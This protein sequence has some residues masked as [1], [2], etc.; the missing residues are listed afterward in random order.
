MTTSWQQLDNIFS[1]FAIC[2]LM[3][4]ALNSQVCCALDDVL[5]TAW[6]PHPSYRGDLT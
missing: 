4:T 3:L 5:F 2:W 1:Q 6:L